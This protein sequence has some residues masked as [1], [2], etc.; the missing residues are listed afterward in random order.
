MTNRLN[1]SMHKRQLVVF[2]RNIHSV[3]LCTCVYALGLVSKK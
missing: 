1:Y 2:V 3:Y